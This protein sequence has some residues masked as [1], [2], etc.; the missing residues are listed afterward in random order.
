VDDATVNEATATLGAG[1]QNS[2]VS[3]SGGWRYRLA[4]DVSY[5]AQLSGDTTTFDSGIP[6]EG[7]AK[8]SNEQ[9]ILPGSGFSV[10]PTFTFGPSP[11][12]TYTVSIR[13]DQASEGSATAFQFGYR[14]RF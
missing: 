6:D 10:A 14:K 11:E 9:R 2:W 1:L 5:V 7:L 12:D 4:L 3:S 13:F 8:F